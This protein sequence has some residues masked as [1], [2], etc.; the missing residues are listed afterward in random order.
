MM[1]MPKDFSKRNLQK[2]SFKEE[3]LSYANFSGSDLR[4]TDFSGSDLSGADFIH[5]RTGIALVNVIFIF[6]VALVLSLF[7]GYVAMLAG[8]T[9]QGM[10]TSEDQKVKIAG[11]ITVV[12]TF[13][14]ILYYYW[15]GGG[16]VLWNLVIPALLLAFAIGIIGY[17]SGLGT[18]MGMLYLVLTF[19]L[20]VFMFIIGTIARAAAGTLSNILFA[21]VALIGS[22]FGKNLGGGIG[23][24]IMAIAC[25]LISK[26]ALSGA[27][28]FETLRKIAL[29][30]TSRFG[31]SFRNT[32]LDN[33][34]FSDSRISNSDFTDADVSSVVWGDSKR[35]NCIINDN[36]FTNKAES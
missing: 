6:I 32:K 4:G 9:V 19:V 34:N 1:Y 15:K 3:D 26:K 7:S 25:A 35:M 24:V 28:G 29:F 16:K 18:G 11:I 2:A 10:L 23:T 13:L 36:L 33:T 14:F 5:V 20:V 22:M 12:I 8:Q 27:S 21:I 31:T 30:I 17:V